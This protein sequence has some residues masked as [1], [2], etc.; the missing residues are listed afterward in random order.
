MPP[1]RDAVRLVDGKQGNPQA[2]QESQHARLHQALRSQVEKLDLPGTDT[3]GDLALLV[4]TQCRV[5]CHGRHAQFIEGR[6]LVFHQ[7]D[8]RRDHHCQ[9][10]AQQAR[11][12]IAQRLA[13]AGG[14]Q[15]QG[16]GACGHALDNRRLLTAKGVVTENIL[17]DM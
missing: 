15:H 17:E 6:D 13:A 14:H 16:I 8:Q 10:F 11:H 5:E 3:L 9:A 7:G 2:L 1:L 4:G 12:L